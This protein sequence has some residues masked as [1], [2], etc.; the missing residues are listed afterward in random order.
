MKY[1]HADQ[2]TKGNH[3]GG[4]FL[5]GGPAPKPIPTCAMCGGETVVLR[6]SP[7]EIRWCRRCRCSI[8]TKVSVLADLFEKRP[9]SYAQL[10]SLVRD[11]RERF[12]LVPTPPPP[13]LTRRDHARDVEVLLWS[14]IG[15][16][17][18]G[19]LIGLIVLAWRFFV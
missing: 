7:V 11:I 12:P 14:M 5:W 17:V 19:I 6:K 2:C 9:R 4:G 18:V 16:A 3:H 10:E 15:S 1:Q 8:E 13:P